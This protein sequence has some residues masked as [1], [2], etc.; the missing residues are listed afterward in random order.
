LPDPVLAP[1]IPPV[2]APIVQVNVLAALDVMVILGLVPLHISLDG[3]LV[4]TGVGFTVTV[5]VKG[6]PG[7]AGVAVEVGV[8][9]Y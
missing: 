3:A 1:V 7:H 9:I 8:M 4:T 6:A 2:M 5:I